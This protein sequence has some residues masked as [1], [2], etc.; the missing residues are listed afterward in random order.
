MELLNISGEDCSRCKNK[1][2]TLDLLSNQQFEIFSQ[3]CQKAKFNSKEVIISPNKS[4]NQVIYLQSGFIKEV[5][6]T[7]GQIELICRI[8]T[9]DSYLALPSLYTE[10]KLDTE[11]VAISPV[12]VCMIDK[13]VFKRLIIENGK[14]AFE[15]LSKCGKENISNYH[16][17]LDLNHKQIYGRVADLLIYLTDH[18]YNNLEFTNLLSR[19]E[20]AS[21][22]NSTRESVTRAIRNFV[23]DGIIT[24]RGHI[25]RIEKREALES[26]SRHG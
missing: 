14:F 6:K 17:F 5:K 26:I 22:I 12:I 20:M 10:K 4:Q 24:S 23:D 16:R 3:S 19:E 18:V 2:C 15:I 11:Y 8:I 7:S 1:S 9:R 21:M 25:I 13:T